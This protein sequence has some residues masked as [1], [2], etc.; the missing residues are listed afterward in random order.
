MKLANSF[1]D[2][3][4]GLFQVWYIRALFIKQQDLILSI[5]VTAYTSAG[6]PVRHVAGSGEVYM[7]FGTAMEISVVTLSAYESSGSN[8]QI[9]MRVVSLEE[10][11]LD[12]HK[13][14]PLKSV[15]CTLRLVTAG[16]RWPWL[17]SRPDHEK[18]AV[19]IGIEF[20]DDL[21]PEP[22][23]EGSL[24]EALKARAPSLLCSA[25]GESLDTA[26]ELSIKFD[27]KEDAEITQADAAGRERRRQ[28]EVPRSLP[29]KT[30]SW[31][32][33]LKV[34]LLM[35]LPPF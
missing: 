5:E 19:D 25:P 13:E 2:N 1:C 28:G 32:L 6:Q 24:D 4:P 33:C 34:C 17:S 30:S 21:M 22:A 9:M 8:T 10:E 11:L 15:M 26:K 20:P 29:L 35:L 14:C 18:V 27:A 23:E 12:V 7:D 16:A 3:A 31:Y